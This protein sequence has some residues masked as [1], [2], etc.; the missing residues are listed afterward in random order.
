MQAF[1][2]MFICYRWLVHYVTR[3]CWHRSKYLQG[4]RC[5]PTERLKN[6]HNSFEE[7]ENEEVLRMVYKWLATQTGKVKTVQLR[8]HNDSQNI[9]HYV[10]FQAHAKHVYVRYVHD[11][12]SNPQ[13][14]TH[15]WRPYTSFMNFT[16]EDI[17][18]SIRR[19]REINNLVIAKQTEE[20]FAPDK[21]I[22]QWLPEMNDHKHLTWMT[23]KLPWR[24]YWSSYKKKTQPKR[25]LTQLR[26]RTGTAE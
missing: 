10:G 1:N 23:T 3:L 21:L 13:R 18:N 9:M 12:L 19:A 7:V 25:T 6:W 16:I 2:R 4:S 17:R 20:A 11:L 15:V 8:I 26:K 22:E 24:K 5:N 14:L